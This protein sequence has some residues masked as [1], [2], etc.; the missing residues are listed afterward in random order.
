VTG[1]G[2][3]LHRPQ[4]SRHDRPAAAA[5]FGDG[6]GSGMKR[7]AR[8][9]FTL[10]SAL[11]LLIALGVGVLWIRSVRMSDAAFLTWAAPR[12]GFERKSSCSFLSVDGGLQVWLQVDNCAVGTAAH[13]PPLEVRTGE[14]RPYPFFGRRSIDPRKDRLTFLQRRGFELENKVKDERAY[15]PSISRGTIAPHWFVLLLSLVL[16]A[17]W[18]RFGLRSIRAA[19]R[20]KMGLC[21]RCGYDLRAS[22]DRCP[23][24]GD[25]VPAGSAAPMVSGAP[26]AHHSGSL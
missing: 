18:L 2:S 12:P 23:E 22:G 6:N 19:R 3:R 10:C 24:C 21:R 25:A 15:P 14:F 13:Y 8:G 4:G 7:I 26:S 16:P 9:L 17:L 11:S 1:E 20:K 5:T